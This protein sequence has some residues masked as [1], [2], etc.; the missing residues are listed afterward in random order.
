MYKN[1]ALSKQDAPDTVV[2]TP[3]PTDLFTSPFSYSL[4]HIHLIWRDIPQHNTMDPYAQPSE[5]DPLLPVD[6]PVKKPFYRPRPLWY[7]PFSKSGGA[8]LVHAFF[9]SLPG[10]S[11][12]R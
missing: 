10:L 11:R 7:S 9:L 12:S 6:P 5:T 4:P 3:D 2:L 1:S 8:S